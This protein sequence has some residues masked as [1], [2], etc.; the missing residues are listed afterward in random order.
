MYDKNIV[1]RIWSKYSDL[2]IIRDFNPATR[3]EEYQLEKAI[4]E[5]RA[6][7]EKLVRDLPSIIESALREGF[8]TSQVFDVITEKGEGL[9][10]PFDLECLISKAQSKID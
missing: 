9:I 8:S 3:G 4:R 6:E 5:T 2:A 7:I 10:P 1:G